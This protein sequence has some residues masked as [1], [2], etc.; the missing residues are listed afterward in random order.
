ML[1]IDKFE[2]ILLLINVFM[3]YIVHFY[4]SVCP[5]VCKTVAISFLEL[6]CWLTE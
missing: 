6:P 1:Q 3:F 2:E 5:C 4:L